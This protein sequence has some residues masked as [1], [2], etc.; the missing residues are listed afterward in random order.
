MLWKERKMQNFMV[1]GPSYRY[2]G[3]INGKPM[4][5]DITHSDFITPEDDSCRRHKKFWLKNPIIVNGK[6]YLP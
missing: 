6:I 2:Q 1:D 3:N 4:F 5:Y